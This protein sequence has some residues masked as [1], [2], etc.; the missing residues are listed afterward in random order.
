MEL[1]QELVKQGFRLNK[2]RR[3]LEKY[4]KEGRKRKNWKSHYRRS[5]RF[6]IKEKCEE[7]ETKKNLTIHHKIPLD[8][9]IIITEENCPTLCEECHNKIHNGNPKKQKPGSKKSIAK[10]KKKIKRN[11]LFLDLEQDEWGSYRIV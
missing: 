11:L 3:C 2:R 8:K 4:T 10:A 7:C 6:F 9:D 1:R 5:S